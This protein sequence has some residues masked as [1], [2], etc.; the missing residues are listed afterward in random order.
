M[1]SNGDSGQPK[2]KKKK[3]KKGMA[4]ELYL[5]KSIGREKKKNHSS[6][7]ENDQTK[8]KSIAREINC[9]PQMTEAMPMD[10]RE[11]V[12]SV[13][14]GRGGKRTPYEIIPSTDVRLIL[15]EYKLDCVTALLGPSVVSL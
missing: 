15:E 7:G 11:D 4:C 3:E 9:I 13:R 5:R 10:V 2:V 12:A 6:C 14:R 8:A 1:G